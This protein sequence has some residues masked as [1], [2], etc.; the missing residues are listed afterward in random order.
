MFSEPRKTEPPLAVRMDTKS[1]RFQ[2]AKLEV[3]IAPRRGHHYNDPCKNG[4]G[5][6]V[7]H[8]CPQSV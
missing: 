4:R 7:G 8:D 6:T 3:R 1:L 5:K 2:I